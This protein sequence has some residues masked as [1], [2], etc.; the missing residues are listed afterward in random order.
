MKRL[1][2]V[3]V[4]LSVVWLAVA[5]GWNAVVNYQEAMDRPAAELIEP[6]WFK[7]PSKCPLKRR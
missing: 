2:T 5:A 6:A 4:A 1:L 3:L 7:G